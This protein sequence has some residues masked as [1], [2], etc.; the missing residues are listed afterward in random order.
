MKGTSLLIQNLSSSVVN[1][2]PKLSLFQ[3]CVHLSQTFIQCLQNQP[4]VHERYTTTMLSK[5][6]PCSITEQ[7]DVLCRLC[8]ASDVTKQIL[9]WLACYLVAGD[10][11]SLLSFVRCV[12]MWKTLGNRYEAMDCKSGHICRTHLELHYPIKSVCTHLL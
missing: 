4:L 9:D 6:P 10:R 3:N 1:G 8:Q 7:L 11:W 5:C 12:K 2:I